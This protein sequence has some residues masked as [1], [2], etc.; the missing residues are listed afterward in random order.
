MLIGMLY[1]VAN[2]KELFDIGDTTLKN[3]CKLVAPFLS[4]TATPP[5][6]K[7]RAFTQEDLT[8]LG[9]IKTAPD[10][11]SAYA[12]LLN[13]QRAEVSGLVAEHSIAVQ[14]AAQIDTL[15]QE[16]TRL[17]QRIAELE[18]EHDL[19][20]A[21]EAERDLLLTLLKPYMKP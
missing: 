14:G 20:I 19:R 2:V 9:I 15:K 8:V 11:Q 10:Y 3:W 7:H 17:N 1:S 21:A 5:G 12:T 16:I 18:R 6:G 13:G 4:P